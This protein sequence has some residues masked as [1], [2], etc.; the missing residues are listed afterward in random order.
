MTIGALVLAGALVGL[1]IALILREIVPAPPDLRT[2]LD[3]LRTPS[4]DTTHTH[5]AG[6]SQRRPGLEAR[7]GGW[8][9]QVATSLGLPVPRRDLDLLGRTVEAHLARKAALA[10]IGLMPAPLLVAVLAVAAVG[11]PVAIPVAASMGLVVLF[12]LLPDLEVKRKATQARSEFR[13]GLCTYVD[14]VALER[15]ADASAVEALE[16][17][18]SPGHGWV[19]DRIRNAVA[20]AMLTGASPWHALIDLADEVGI[21][22]LSDVGDII[23]VSGEDGAAVHDTL[24]AHARALRTTLLTEYETAA[25]AASER[26]AIPVACLGLMFIA[27][28]IF[29][30]LARILII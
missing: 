8:L 2:T 23:A 4:T 27:A 9:R 14:L 3:R 17:A 30:A 18:A 11:V 6:D 10:L 28:L 22:E 19:F 16:R 1:G 24:R 5:A 15:L 21:S 29:P 20:H 26:L 7:L 25:N 13:R 12:F